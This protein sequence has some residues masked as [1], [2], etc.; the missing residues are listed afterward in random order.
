VDS[1]S[2]SVPSTNF[3]A[4]WS[5]VD[6]T[7]DPSFYVG[8]LD[9]T[10]AATLDQARRDPD[11]V[12][13]PLEL[14][15]GLGVLHAGCGTG[16]YLRLLAPLVAPGRAVGIDLSATLIAEV[17]QREAHGQDTV[18]SKGDV[19]TSCLSPMGPST[20][21]W[22]PRSC[23]TWRTPWAG[24]GRR[25]GG[26][27]SRGCRCSGARRAWWDNGSARWL[28]GG[29]DAVKQQFDVLNLPQAIKQ[30]IDIESDTPGTLPGRRPQHLHR[31]CSRRGTTADLDLNDHRR[32][33]PAPANSG[34]SL[35]TT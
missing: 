9:A 8:L 20:A 2:D 15:A 1:R 31:E 34:R 7:A 32:S 22:P 5:Q 19:P 26:C 33:P 12:L 13:D 25:C 17:L 35:S 16:G 23:C 3:S 14:R 27:S 10:R 29:G 11:L 28:A 18:C 4:S 24:C 6:Q 21:S 30:G